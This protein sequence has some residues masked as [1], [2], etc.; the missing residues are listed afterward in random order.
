MVCADD[1]SDQELG[2]VLGFLTHSVRAT[3]GMAHRR[4]MGEEGEEGPLC[5]RNS[6]RAETV[7]VPSPAAGCSPSLRSPST[8]CH[9]E[10]PKVPSSVAVSPNVRTYRAHLS[11]APFLDRITDPLRGEDLADYFIQVP[12]A[13]S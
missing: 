13:F 3:R 8:P 7:D 9:Q 1:V 11:T 12:F 6:G 5:K 2:I 10:Q 4:L